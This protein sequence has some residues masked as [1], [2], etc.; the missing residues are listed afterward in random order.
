MHQQQYMNP[1]MQQMQMQQQPQYGYY[2]H[3]PQTQQQ[4]LHAGGYGMH[5]GGGMMG[6]PQNGY[7]QSQ[8]GMGQWGMSPAS[9]APNTN[10]AQQP[11]AAAQAPQFANLNPF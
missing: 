10:Y 9:S 1:Q 4:H 7:M 2:Q 3:M 11:A 6:M 8:P 5:P